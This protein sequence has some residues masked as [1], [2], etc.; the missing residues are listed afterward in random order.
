MTKQET[1]DS[2]MAKSANNML[3]FH[4]ERTKKVLGQVLMVDTVAEA[5]EIIKSELEA[6]ELSMQD[7]QEGMSV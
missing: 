6:I 1:I 3:I 5:A 2:I 4:S 7:R